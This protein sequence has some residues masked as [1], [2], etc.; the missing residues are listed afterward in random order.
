MRTEHKHSSPYR[1]RKRVTNQCPTEH[2]DKNSAAYSLEY[3]DDSKSFIWSSP[4][5]ILVS[6]LEGTLCWA[7][8][9][10]RIA[11]PLQLKGHPAFVRGPN[12]Y[13]KKKN[14]EVNS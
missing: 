11:M 4:N 14:L 10:C 7:E 3:T 12:R 13:K 8:H 9:L 6:V 2:A 5:G 1:T